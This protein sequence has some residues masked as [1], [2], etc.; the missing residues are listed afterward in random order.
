[1]QQTTSD[2]SWIYYYDPK[3]K[4][5]SAQRVF[6]VEEL[7]IKLKSG[8]IVGKEM[9]VSFFGITAPTS[10]HVIYKA[11]T[12]VEEVVAVYEQ[13]VETTPKCEWANCFSRQCRKWGGA[14]GAQEQ[15]VDS[16]WRKN[17]QTKQDY[18]FFGLLLICS[19]CAPSARAKQ[20]DEDQDVTAKD[21]VLSLHVNMDGSA[22]ERMNGK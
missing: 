5:P 16:G 19:R 3:T 11:V 4:R 13:A 6:P 12:E 10:H 18:Y 9:V 8:R 7:P 1:M 15:G 17:G 21:I 2:E 20:Q 22:G 14:T